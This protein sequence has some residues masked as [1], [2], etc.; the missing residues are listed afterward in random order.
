MTAS[1]TMQQ[2]KPNPVPSQCDR[3]AE[4]IAAVERTLIEGDDVKIR[5]AIKE[6]GAVAW[7]LAPQIIFALTASS[8]K[9]DTMTH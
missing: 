2:R 1:Q 3:F 8:G 6:A 5:D 9:T 4:A 7:N